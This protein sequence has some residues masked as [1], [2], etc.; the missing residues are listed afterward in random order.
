MSRTHGNALYKKIKEFKDS[1]EGF[2]L[3][4]PQIDEM[5]EVVI[6]SYIAEV[7]EKCKLIDSGGK[8]W[9]NAQYL[10]PEANR[11][12]RFKSNTGNGIVEQEGVYDGRTY[13]ADIPA[14]MPFSAAD[15]WKYI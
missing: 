10:E 7:A 12:I 11:R 15:S 5:A 14:T 6:Q 2:C 9:V 3:S 8:D 1:K 4:D 13:C